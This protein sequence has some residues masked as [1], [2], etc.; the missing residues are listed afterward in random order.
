MQH[1][2]VKYRFMNVIAFTTENYEKTKTPSEIREC[3]PG[4]RFHDQN[5]L[6]EMNLI[7]GEPAF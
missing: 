6:V 4:F 1:A 5:M 2:L 3:L 7:L